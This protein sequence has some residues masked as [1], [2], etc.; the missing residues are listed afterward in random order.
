MKLDAYAPDSE[1]KN[2]VSD[3]DSNTEYTD[4]LPE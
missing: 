1:L 3:Y 4:N 2:R